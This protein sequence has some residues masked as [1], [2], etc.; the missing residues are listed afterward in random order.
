[1]LKDGGQDVFSG[2]R[3]WSSSILNA[4]LALH[5]R[6]L[7]IGLKQVRGGFGASLEQDRGGLGAGQERP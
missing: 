7:G 6:G 4:G 5:R 1:M 3:R 2:E